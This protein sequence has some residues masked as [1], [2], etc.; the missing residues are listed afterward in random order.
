MR[1]A[2]AVDENQA[3]VVEAFRKAGASVLHLHQV[4]Q[5]CPDVLVGVG[6]IDQQVEIKDGRKPPSQRRLTTA[7][8]KHHRGWRGRPVAIVECPEDAVALVA[9]MRWPFNSEGNE[10]IMDRKGMP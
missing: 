6:N 2:A 3:E 4:G 1:R 9:R 8:A 7:E 5:G 10:Y